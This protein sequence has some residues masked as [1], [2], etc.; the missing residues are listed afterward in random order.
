MS[1]GYN[2]IN[3][4]LT[5]EEKEEYKRLF[6]E[7]DTNIK[8][9]SVILSSDNKQKVKQFIEEHMHRDMLIEYG[10][11]PM[12][13]ILMYGAS[14]TGKTYLSKALC[15]HL[16]YTML[17][18]DIADSLSR[19]NVAENISNIFKIANKLGKCVIFLD[20]CDSIAWSRDAVQSDGGDIRRATNSIFQQLD[21]MNSS[22]IF[23]GATNMLYRIDPAFERRFNIKMEFTRPDME[24][25]D[26]INHFILPKFKLRDNSDKTVYEI[27]SRR[28]ADNKKISYYEIQCVV[29][30]AMKKA[31]I[32]GTNIVN[33]SDIYEDMQR[34]M[35]INIRYKGGDND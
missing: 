12:N 14:G 17:Y 26:T 22:N 23:I 1:D 20:E 11:K 4:K 18:I 27:M 28:V 35:N 34:T 10:L 8:M 33:T 2:R 25:I 32:N 24:L 9:S 29:E 31:I 3:N 15:N 6:M 30:R 5:E 7:V 19:G 16:G 13:R 21:Q